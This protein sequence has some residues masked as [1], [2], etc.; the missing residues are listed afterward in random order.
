LSAKKI[1]LPHL[2]RL[3][4]LLSSRRSESGLTYDQLAAASGVSRRTIVSVESGKSPGSM[5]TWFRL[6]TALEVGFDELFTATTGRTT[7]TVPANTW[8]GATV[9]IRAELALGTTSDVPGALHADGTRPHL[10]VPPPRVIA[11]GS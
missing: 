5:E 8:P 7:N 4:E 6:A 2:D 9:V 3:R 11:P 1:P 10:L